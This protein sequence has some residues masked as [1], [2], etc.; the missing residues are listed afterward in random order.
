M[1]ELISGTPE[2]YERSG[3]GTRSKNTVELQ[4]LSEEKQGNSNGF[5]HVYHSGKRY[6]IF[7]YYHSVIWKFLY[8]RFSKP[9]PHIDCDLYTGVDIL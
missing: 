1:F 8:Y 5:L 6:Q 7:C 9:Y 3:P 4:K 2:I